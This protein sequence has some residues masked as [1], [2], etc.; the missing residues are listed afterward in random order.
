MFDLN[1]KVKEA[2]NEKQS[3]VTALK[4]LHDDYANEIAN[5]S[6]GSA[7]ASQKSGSR[8]AGQNNVWRKSSANM[9]LDRCPI[10]II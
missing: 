3:L 1:T 8:D 7:Q 4:V 9:Q 5:R 10:K 2:E 6:C